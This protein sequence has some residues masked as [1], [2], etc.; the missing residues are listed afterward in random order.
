MEIKF[1]NSSKSFIKITI[2]KLILFYSFNKLIGVMTDCKIYTCKCTNLT[3]TNI[4][5]LKQILFDYNSNKLNSYMTTGL[6]TK[7]ENI[8]DSLDLLKIDSILAR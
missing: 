8:I 1:L 4:N 7:F 2:G 3:P 6:Q 5:H